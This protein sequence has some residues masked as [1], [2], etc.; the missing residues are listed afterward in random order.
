MGW[1]LQQM[2]FI[3]FFSLVNTIGLRF[4]L[5]L[6]LPD[7]LLFSDKAEQAFSANQLDISL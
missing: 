1:L 7:S 2:L 3:L 4:S 5:L 6:T